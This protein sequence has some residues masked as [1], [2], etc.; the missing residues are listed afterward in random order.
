MSEESASNKPFS[1]ESDAESVNQ[2][3]QGLQFH[4]FNPARHGQEGAITLEFFRRVLQPDIWTSVRP[5][6]P[7][8]IEQAARYAT[9]YARLFHSQHGGTSGWLED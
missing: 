5:L 3:S 6:Q 1:Y 2:P 9:Y 8:T 7:Y 4:S